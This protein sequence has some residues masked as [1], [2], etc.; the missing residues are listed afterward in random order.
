MTMKKDNKV[1]IAGEHYNQTNSKKWFANFVVKIALN[2]MALIYNTVKK[3]RKYLRYED[4]WNNIAIGMSTEN[5]AVAQTIIF[6]EGKVKVVSG[7]KKA[8]CILTAKDPATL[9]LMAAIPPNEVMLLLLTNEMH[10]SGNL[11]KLQ[12]FNFLI[13]VVLK[14]KQAKAILK[15]SEDITKS[16]KFDAHMEEIS[17]EEAKKRVKKYVKADFVDKGVEFIKE[18]QYLSKYSLDDFPR[19]KPFLDRHLNDMP[20][21]CLER[22]RLI[23]DWH[24]ENGFETQ[25]DGKAW[26]ATLRQGLMFKSLIEQ[27]KTVIRKSDLLAGT[28]TA[29]EVGVILYPDSVAL[30]IWAEFFSTDTRPYTPYKRMTDAEIEELNGKHFPYWLNRNFREYVR[31]TYDEPIGQKA[32]ER[33]AVNYLW[34]TTALSHTVI[35]HE[36]FL[37]IGADGI[38]AECDAEIKKTDKSNIK[39]INTV[40][41]IK[42][43]YEGI[44]TYT[45]RLVL[46]AYA[47][48]KV[49]KNEVRK[50][51][52]VNMGDV[53]N[54]IAN[55][56]VE[57]Y[58]EAMQALWIHWIAVHLENFNAG[59]SIGRVDQLMQPY[60]AKSFKACKT[61]NEKDKF[62]KH[63]IDLMGCLFMAMTDH[64]PL[65]PDMGNHLFGAAGANQAITLGGVTPAGDDAVNDMTYVI[66]KVTEMLG[67]RDPNI[68]AR[69]HNKMNSPAY[70]KRLCE[71]NVNTCGTPSIHNDEI[72]MKSLEDFNFQQDEL[73]NWSATGCVEPTITGKHIGHTNCMMFNTVA[74]LEMTLN[75][76]YHPLMRWQL[77]PKT[78]D[79]AN[80]KT[81]DEF[82]EAFKTQTF[83]LLDISVDYN[84]KLGEA[85]SIIRPTPMISGCV[86]GCIEKGKDVT[87]GGAK[88]N[89]SGIACIGLADITDSL[90]AV[91]KLVFEENKYTMAE[92]C[93][94]IKADFEGYEEMRQF[95]MNSVAQFGS[96]DPN[97]T[98]MANSVTK[99][100]S[101]YMWKQTNFR[102]GRYTTGWWSM[103]NHVAFGTL[104]GALP[105]GRLS[106]K[107]FTPGLTPEPTASRNL[108]DNLAAV[109]QLEPKTLNNN[110]AF[111][112]KVTPSANDTHEQTVSHLYN[113]AKAYC[114]LGGMQ[115]QYN[116][117]SSKQMRAAMANPDQY[118]DLLVRI[119]GYNAYFVQ[120]NKEMQLELINR[121]EYGLNG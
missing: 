93:N 14:K 22:V 90:L 102:G 78:G 100:I 33:F 67:L 118:K 35:D 25:N 18:D 70:L 116:V 23:T 96:S 50:A 109:A 27:H 53:C 65:V 77:G 72:V 11:L 8:E 107:P 64:Q 60:F 17:D 99:F 105:S 112:V 45:K 83:S 42:A 75:N 38:V 101:E 16:R 92:V 87:L 24:K 54:N 119:S 74:C 46:Q 114:D 69:F 115:M 104:T 73:N 68:N 52:L 58:D 2:V 95:L 48:A 34:K 44:S 76:G 6:N 51:E 19:L 97:A 57:T 66:L 117:I 110:I 21:F 41:A 1:F 63:S 86:E 49:E 89:S 12:Y 28:T 81:F 26:D 59:F 43:C 3:Y 56:K 39:K 9:K 91:K 85:H 71:V 103:S 15:S 121:A 13:A 37:K 111:N 7:L 120:C 88:Y 55:G 30:A 5:G 106:G 47:D 98:K 36:R 94:A 113:Y 40:N 108:L 82:F 31:N 79:P 29:K 61:E 20:E 4:G 84:N 10:I 32:D 80:F 62:V